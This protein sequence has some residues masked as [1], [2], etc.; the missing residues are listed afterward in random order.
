MDK[1]E[2]IELTR[3]QRKTIYELFKDV[4]KKLSYPPRTIIEIEDKKMDYIYIITKGYVKQYYIYLD[5]N[6]KFLF[7]LQKGDIFGEISMIQCACD[8]V[9][10]QTIDYVI[11]EKISQDIFFDKLAKNPEYNR[12]LYQMFTGKIRKLMMQIYDYS[13]FDIQTSILHLLQRLSIEYGVEDNQGIKIIPRLT[14]QDIASMIGSTRSTV[15]RKLNELQ[16]DGYIKKVGRDIYIC[17]RN[18]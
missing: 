8:D 5:G 1:Y 4:G 10:T 17:N 13:F 14:H 2:N 12:F 11:V 3:M 7:L 9:I 6:T 15:T 18:W 16:C